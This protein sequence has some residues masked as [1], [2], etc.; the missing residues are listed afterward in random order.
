MIESTHC[1]FFQQVGS[2]WNTSTPSTVQK[3]TPVAWLSVQQSH[4]P[5]GFGSA[6]PCLPSKWATGQ[7]SPALHGPVHFPNISPIQLP[8]MSGSFAPMKMSA[9]VAGHITPFESKKFALLAVLTYLS[10]A[11]PTPQFSGMKTKSLVKY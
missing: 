6:E 5:C 8:M 3:P 7:D 9:I 10:S 1:L 4:R 11:A 2:G